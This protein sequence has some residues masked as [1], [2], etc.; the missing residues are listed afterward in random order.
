MYAKL[1]EVFENYI[2]ACKRINS[3][4]PVDQRHM[5]S[6]KTFE[7]AREFK[8]LIKDVSNHEKIRKL[9]WE[10]QPE[11]HVL[12]AWGGYAIP[13]PPYLRNFFENTGIYRKIRYE[14]DVDINKVF[15]TFLEETEKQ[16][17]ITYSGRI[18]GVAIQFGDQK[19]IPLPFGG[20]SIENWDDQSPDC[21]IDPHIVKRIPVEAPDGSEDF[22]TEISSLGFIINLYCPN[23][24]FV[25]W[26]RNSSSLFSSFH[27]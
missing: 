26:S 21:V 16:M 10:W 18:L 20:F 17:Q 3:L 13:Q 8:E 9:G 7:E 15:D 23:P 14:E 1:F 12:G 6:V 4:L 22:D 24:V 19:Q 25:T 5:D 27:S 2:Q 11:T